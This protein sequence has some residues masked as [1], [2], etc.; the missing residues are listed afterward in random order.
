MD[1]DAP[2]GLEIA[3]RREGDVTVIAASGEADLAG[4][5]ALRAALAEAVDAPG[6]DVVVDLARV[7][8]LDST[9]LAALLNAL[10]RLRRAGRSLVVAGAEPQVLKVIR[11]AHLEDDFACVPTVGAA[12]ARRSPPR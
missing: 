8:L 12:L 9:G 7:T 11:L 4:T 3:V 6:G 5:P 10:R 2:A 1:D